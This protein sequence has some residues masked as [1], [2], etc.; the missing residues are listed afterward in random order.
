M[1]NWCPTALQ[2]ISSL[3]VSVLLVKSYRKH[4]RQFTLSDKS[5]LAEGLWFQHKADYFWRGSF[6]LVDVYTEKPG[7]G[8]SVSTVTGLTQLS[9]VVCNIC[10][11]KK[12]FKWIEL[13]VI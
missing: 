2:R 11:F 6:C 9:A 13:S 12:K 5:F 8:F 4:L 10:I 3:N 7:Q 1:I